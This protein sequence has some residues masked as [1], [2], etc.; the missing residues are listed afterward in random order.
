MQFSLD[1]LGSPV[2]TTAEG[3]HIYVFVHVYKYIILLHETHVISSYFSISV[4]QPQQI[5]QKFSLPENSLPG[6]YIGTVVSN[7]HGVRFSIV[8]VLV[9]DIFAINEISGQLYLRSPL[10][11]FETTTEYHLPVKLST[12]G[13]SNHSFIYVKVYVSDVIDERPKFSHYE[14]RANINQLTSSGT[15]VVQLSISDGD[16]GDTLHLE[17]LSYGYGSL[18]LFTL[19]QD[20]RYISTSRMISDSD[21]RSHDLIVVATDRAGLSSYALVTIDIESVHNPLLETL[22][23]IS[24]YMVVDTFDYRG[25]VQHLDVASVPNVVMCTIEPPP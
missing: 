1:Q 25:I 3:K 22:N 12:K 21:V 15:R 2:P 19:Y 9:A 7:I 18:G 23:V 5:L 13:V 20:S 4:S 10:L 6:H 8:D 24:D 11:D 16:Q 17:L 14:Y